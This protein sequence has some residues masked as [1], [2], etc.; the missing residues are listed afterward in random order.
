MSI[1]VLP[2][3]DR[4]LTFMLERHGIYTRRFVEKLPPPWTDDPILHKFKFCNVYRELDK[5]TIWIREHIRE[6]YAKHPHLWFML[7]I[8]RQINWPDTL[9]ELIVDKRSGWPTVTV[10]SW[11]RARDILRSRQVR[12]EK[13]YTGAYMLRG[14]IQGDPSGDQDKPI[15]TCLRVLQP[16]WVD[17]KQI[18]SHMSNTLQEAHTALVSNHG[19]GAFLAAQVVADIKHTRYLKGASD[20]WDWAVLGPGS[21]RGL[22]RVLNRS[23]KQSFSDTEAIEYLKTFRDYMQKNSDLPRFCLQ[24]MQ[25]A[26]CEMDKYERVRL[27]EG[28]PRALFTSGI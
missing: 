26:L 27:G 2:G 4:L 3:I 6:P 10:W 21:L 17:R 1:K 9:Q 28:R 24:D 20:W 14:P 19:W 13:T 8:A 18:S 5:V 7:C 25:N 12:G 16:V 15:Y 11:Q 22:N 23:I